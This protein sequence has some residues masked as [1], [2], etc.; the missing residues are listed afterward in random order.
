MVSHDISDEKLDTLLASRD[1]EHILIDT[2]RDTCMQRLSKQGRDVSQLSKAMNKLDEMK[3][4]NKFA[5]FKKI[6][7]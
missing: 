2:D 3:S 6:K 1:V 5:K 4:E 7:N